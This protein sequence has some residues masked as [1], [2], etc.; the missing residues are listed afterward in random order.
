MVH[1]LSA[2]EM[3]AKLQSKELSSVEL[4]RALLDRAEQMNSKLR[5]YTV[6]REEALEEAQR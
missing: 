6:I 3:L 5:A 4:T 1:T 2:A